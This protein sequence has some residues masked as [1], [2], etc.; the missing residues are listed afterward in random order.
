[1]KTFTSYCLILLFLIFSSCNSQNSGS[2]KVSGSESTSEGV[3]DFLVT[4]GDGKKNS[5]LVVSILKEGK[6]ISKLTSSKSSPPKIEPNESYKFMLELNPKTSGVYYELFQTTGQGSSLLSGAEHDFIF[7][8]GIYHFTA[9]AIKNQ[10]PID[11]VKFMISVVCELSNQL[12]FEIYPENIKVKPLFLD[13]QPK[14]GI[15]DVIL[16]QFPDYLNL[17]EYE[18]D[19]SGVLSPDGSPHP[20]ADKFVAM[21]D[22][23]GTNAFDFYL[24]GTPISKS[25]TFFSSYSGEGREF[26]IRVYNN[27]CF[28]HVEKKFTFPSTAGTRPSPFKETAIEEGSLNSN[29]TLLIDNNIEHFQQ[30]LVSALNEPGLKGDLAIFGSKWVTKYSSSVPVYSLDAQKD[31]NVSGSGNHFVDISTQYTTQDLYIAPPENPLHFL[32]IKT[33]D[34]KQLSDG[35]ATFLNQDILDYKISV[36]GEKDNNQS[37]IF[38]YKCNPLTEICKKVDIKVET[39]VTTTTQSETRSCGL[40]KAYDPSKPG[41]FLP[42]SCKWERTVQSK[43]HEIHY[44][45]THHNSPISLKSKTRPDRSFGVKWLEG[46]LKGLQSNNIFGDWKNSGECDQNRTTC[47]VLDN[48]YCRFP[49]GIDDSNNKYQC[50]FG[51][52]NCGGGCAGKKVA[53]C[54]AN[55]SGLYTCQ[56][57]QGTYEDDQG[58][59]ICAGITCAKSGTIPAYCKPTSNPANAPACQSIPGEWQ[60]GSG[61]KISACG[62]SCGNFWGTQPIVCSKNGVP[63]NPG[64]YPSCMGWIQGTNQCGG[65]CFVQATGPNP[66]NVSGKPQCGTQSGTNS[67]GT[68]CTVTYP[69]ACVE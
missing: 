39:I 4:P 21:M 6:V 14:D 68:S 9:R 30:G 51:T 56:S 54:N 26:K 55:N 43:D 64:S 1:M 60:D 20:E 38:N 58:N 22:I 65:A 44:A 17:G 63:I 16:G 42:V 52:N 31:S 61:N 7:N 5:S 67:C 66:C 48:T 29:P 62:N 10:K 59:P 46:Y 36:V 32:R 53:R 33:P 47:P 12:S 40:C 45:K 18:F 49:G 25:L 23:D 41:D 34:L 11:Q 15:P 27:E 69:Q 57:A 8:P 13:V 24:P 2:E 28:N 3:D 19:L 50:E 37:E 35:T